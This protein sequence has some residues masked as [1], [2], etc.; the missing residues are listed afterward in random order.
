MHVLRSERNEDAREAM[1]LTTTCWHIFKSF[2]SELWQ[3]KNLIL[4]L[5]IW[6]WLWVF[7]VWSTQRKAR[8]QMGQEC[9]HWM[10]P[11]MKFHKKSTK[12]QIIQKNPANSNS[13]GKQKLVQVSRGSSYQTRCWFWFTLLVINKESCFYYSCIINTHFLAF[14]LYQV[15]L[16][17]NI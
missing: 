14:S 13:Q 2:A 9:C 12:W 17:K 11:T 4:L 5:K 16:Y 6:V 3:N 10:Y 8:M 7:F 1:S 15:L